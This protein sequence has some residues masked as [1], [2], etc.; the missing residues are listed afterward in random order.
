MV[1]GESSEIAATALNPGWNV[2]MDALALTN[3]RMDVPDDSACIYR[4]NSP[5]MKDT[6][7]HCH[8]LRISR[9]ILCTYLVAASGEQ[10]LPAY[11]CHP[12]FCS[13]T[14]RDTWSAQFSGFEHLSRTLASHPI[15]FSSLR[16]RSV[17]AA[18][19]GPR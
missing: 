5:C 3:P 15:S 12:P 8:L 10:I 13:F 9:H 4:R 2:V 1:A 16:L 17:D 6:K 14:G 11:S 7:L 18:T 19:F